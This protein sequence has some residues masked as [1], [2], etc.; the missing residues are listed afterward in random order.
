MEATTIVRV[1]G[2]FIDFGPDPSKIVQAKRSTS[3]PPASTA[4]HPTHS[5][6]ASGH[7]QPYLA[8]WIERAD[9]LSPVS[10]PEK[11]SRRG[12]MP[13]T[14]AQLPSSFYLQDEVGCFQECCPC[15]AALNPGF[16]FCHQCG[17]AKD[18]KCACGAKYVAEG[19][20]CHQCGHAKDDMV[21]TISATPNESR[22][23]WSDLPALPGSRGVVERTE[24][25][26]RGSTCTFMYNGHSDSCDTLPSMGSSG[27]ETSS[28]RASQSLLPQP[29][30]PAAHKACDISRTPKGQRSRPVLASNIGTAGAVA[31][32]DESAV[33]IP[34]TTLMICDIPCRQTINQVVDAI[35]EHGYAGTYDLVY[36]PPQKGFRRPKHSQNMGY[37][38]IN[39]KHAEYATAFGKVFHD[40]PFPHCSSTKLSYTK[41]AHRQ[42]FQANLEMHS[43]ERTSA[44]CLLTFQ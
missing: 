4:R 12:K 31:S 30:P 21:R 34:I 5:E 14:P 11:G 26:S 7:Y 20:F 41:P 33:G 1:R 2:T 25:F 38:F 16:H 15:G 42:G 18:A 10:Q 28:T 13:Q 17:H 19:R 37:A 8:G 24:K 39:F 3:L 32:C 40:Y 43:K 36:M 35:N 23:R 44:G 6:E 9:S 29:P 22:C 27:R